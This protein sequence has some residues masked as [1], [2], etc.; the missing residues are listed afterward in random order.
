VVPEQVQRPPGTA[1]ALDRDAVDRHDPGLEGAAGEAGPACAQLGRGGDGDEPTRPVGLEAGP[2]TRL[3]LDE[4]DVVR[5]VGGGGQQLQ[6]AG[7]VLDHQPDRAGRQQPG[8]V[9][10]EAVGEVQRL[11]AVGEHLGDVVDRRGDGISAYVH[12]VLHA[13]GRCPAGRP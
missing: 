6:V 9:V 7:G 4:F 8:A 13:A 1:A 10:H 11:A 3:Q 12:T 2:L 5:V